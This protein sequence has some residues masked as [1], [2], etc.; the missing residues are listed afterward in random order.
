MDRELNSWVIMN[1][2]RIFKNFK[3]WLMLKNIIIMSINDLMM[4]YVRI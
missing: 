2:Y 3:I 4:D 1:V